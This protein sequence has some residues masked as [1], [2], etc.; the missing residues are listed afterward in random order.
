MLAHPFPFDMDRIYDQFENLFADGW[1]ADYSQFATNPVPFSPSAAAPAFLLSATPNTANAVN[2]GLAAF[3]LVFSETMDNTV[4]PA[5][6]FGLL[7]P[8]T[9]NVVVAEGWVT[10]NIWRGHFAVGI[11]TGDGLNTLR[12]AG[13]KASDGFVIPDDTYH[14]FFIDTAPGTGVSNGVAVP[15]TPTSLHLSWDPS[16]DADLIGYSIRRSNSRS[17]PY[18]FVKSLPA[19]ELETVDEDLESGVT[20]FY[21]VIEYDSSLNSRQLTS[22]FSGK[23]LNE[24]DPTATP[25]STPDGSLTPTPTAATTPEEGITPTPS[26]TRNYDVWPEGGDGEI[27]A[28]DLLEMLLSQPGSSGLFEF[29][30]KW[31]KE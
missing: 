6:T 12:V 5:V 17:G 27:D 8:F 26:S 21:Q 23:T 25:I 31:Q 3:D 22:P 15:L 18:V 10:P 2:V 20:Y 29:S 13:A 4:T 16:A 30:K 19:H 1:L 11:E 7:S 24:G 14:Q 9:D 28:R